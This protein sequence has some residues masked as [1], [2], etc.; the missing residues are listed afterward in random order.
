MASTDYS[1]GTLVG[2]YIGG[3]LISYGTSHDMEFSM[4]PREA[5][6]KDSNGWSEVREGQKSWTMSG[7]FIFAE[8]ASYGFSDLFTLAA[9]RTK[10]TV[11]MSTEVAGDKA[12]NGDAYIT[13]VSK[14]SP[15]ENTETFSLSLQGT[16]AI[17]E[18]TIS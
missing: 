12:Y 3:T 15:N 2:L 13:S 18:T 14:S 1:N 9:A 8:D 17:T 16:G 4:S 10:I 7:E 6:N 11:K 5:S